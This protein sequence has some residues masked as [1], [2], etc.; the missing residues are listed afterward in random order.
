MRQIIVHNDFVGNIRR[1]VFVA[2]VYIIWVKKF[3]D[4]VI[5]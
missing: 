1:F 2:Y 5:V 4:R 3:P